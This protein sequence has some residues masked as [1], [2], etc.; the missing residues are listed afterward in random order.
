MILWVKTSGFC[1]F[2]HR[3]IAVKPRQDVV[4]LGDEIGRPRINA[5]ARAGD[6][7]HERIDTTM[8]Q[9]LVV[10]LGL[11]YGRSVI[12]LARE[13]HRRRGDVTYQRQR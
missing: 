1:G 12:F 4:D 2:A 10:L 5:L 6:A 13:Q 3:P 8:L 7:D 11:A 9:G